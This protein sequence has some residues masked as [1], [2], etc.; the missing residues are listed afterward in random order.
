M[1]P[2]ELAKYIDHTLLKPDATRLQ[3]LRI[4]EDLGNE[5]SP[6]L[7]QSHGPAIFAVSLFSFR[8]VNPALP[9]AHNSLSGASFFKTEGR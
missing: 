4:C 3:I 1:N 7:F 5:P 8:R 9:D 6:A 2:D